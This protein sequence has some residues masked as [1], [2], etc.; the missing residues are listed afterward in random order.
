MRAIKYVCRMY[1]S[2]QFNKLVTEN[3]R[4][5]TVLQIYGRYP[6]IFSATF[7]L[8]VTI[9]YDDFWFSLKIFNNLVQFR[10]KLFRAIFFSFLSPTD[11]IPLEEEESSG[12]PGEVI[13]ERVSRQSLDLDLAAG[14]LSFT[15]E[16]DL[17]RRGWPE[18]SSRMK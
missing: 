6:K 18:A 3:D 4:K 8:N 14:T 2:R 17:E 1:V 5:L 15:K 16:E 9:V 13:K 10:K 11:T 12:S 7:F